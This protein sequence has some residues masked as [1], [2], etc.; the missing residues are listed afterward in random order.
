MLFYYSIIIFDFSTQ[1][2]ILIRTFYNAVTY[3]PSVTIR[4]VF[5]NMQANMGIQI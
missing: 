3:F 2:N 4:F 5:A 1:L